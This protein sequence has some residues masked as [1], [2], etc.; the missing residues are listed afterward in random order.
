MQYYYINQGPTGAFPALNT[1]SR[2]SRLTKLLETSHQ[3]VEVDPVSRRRIYCWIDANVPYYSTWD[4][5]RPHTCGGRDTWG[6]TKGLLPWMQ[7]IEAVTRRMQ[8]R[9]DRPRKRVWDAPIPHTYINL[10]H[11]QWSRL[12]V[13]NLAKS[14]GGT[15]ADEQAVFETTSDP[16]YQAILSAIEEGR[17]LLEEKPRMDMPGAV[18]VPQV[19][20]FGRVF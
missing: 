1:G 17:R 15:A 14:A 13:E 18:A 4:M 10:T 20:D 9:P 12:L 6:D 5:S 7:K 3:G 2:V 19:R 16:D 11:P 8:F